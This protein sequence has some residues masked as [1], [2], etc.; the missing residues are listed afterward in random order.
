[1]RLLA[2]FAGMLVTGAV[3]GQE[4]WLDCSS[5]NAGLQLKVGFDQQGQWVEIRSREE[6]LQARTVNVTPGKVF[7]ETGVS[8]IE[9]DRISGKFQYRLLRYERA[10]QPPVRHGGGDGECVR[11]GNVPAGKF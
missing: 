9:I 3:F 1:V 11:T 2:C 5:F 4:T 6:I 7:G 8:T 10:G